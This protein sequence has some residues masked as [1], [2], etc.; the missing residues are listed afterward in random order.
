[1]YREVRY[2]PTTPADILDKSKD[3]L[4]CRTGK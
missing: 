1:M 3:E 2:I 4:K